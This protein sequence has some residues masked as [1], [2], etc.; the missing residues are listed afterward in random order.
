LVT[1]HDAETGEV[2]FKA[3]PRSSPRTGASARGPCAPYRARI[4]GKDKR[5][6]GYAK[7]N[8]VAGHAFESWGALEAHLPWWKREVADLRVHGATGEP[9]ILRFERDE[10]AALT[11]I[12][13][14]PPFREIRELVRKVQADCAVEVDNNAYSAP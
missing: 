3:R 6:V 4:K 1:L 9:P 10:A 5:G 8:T 13:G 11:P 12:A 7:R 2:T 14:R